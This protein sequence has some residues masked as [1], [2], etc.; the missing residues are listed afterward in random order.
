M[1]Y[2]LIPLLALLSTGCVSSFD[3]HQAKYSTNRIT[4]S[5]EL[6]ELSVKESA[7]GV[8]TIQIGNLLQHYFTGTNGTCTLSLIECEIDNTVPLLGRPQN[9]THLTTKL[10][11]SDGQ[12]FI[13]SATGDRKTASTTS[14][15]QDFEA[16]AIDAARKTY[17]SA[18]NHLGKN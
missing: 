3:T 4:L 18:M 14:L 8:H 11:T 1:K 13:I 2:I 15:K 10:T 17:F 5:H 9:A 12:E 7:S 16:D 6:R